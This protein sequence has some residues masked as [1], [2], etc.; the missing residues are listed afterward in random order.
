MYVNFLISVKRYL[1][2]SNNYFSD[3]KKY[4]LGDKSENSKKAQYLN[5]IL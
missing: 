2:L 5:I 3:H 1:L 4:L